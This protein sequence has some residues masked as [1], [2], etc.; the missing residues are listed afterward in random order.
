MGALHAGHMELVNAARL[1][2]DRVIVSVFVNPSQFDDP[3]DLLIYPKRADH[4][5]ALLKAAGVDALFSPDVSDI[6]PDGAETVVHPTR[7]ANILI[8]LERPGHFQGVA[9]V[10]TKLFNIVTPDFA[11]FGQK[12][13]QQLQ[14]IK[15]LVR[16]LCFPIEIIDH[17]TVRDATGLALSSRNV[18]LSTD[19][20]TAATVLNKALD[21][22]QAAV[23]AQISA[24]KLYDM[25]RTR[26]S[27]EPRA[28]IRTIDIVSPDDLS[29]VT[30]QVSD[31][32]AILLAVEFGDVLLIDQRVMHPMPTRRD[33]PTGS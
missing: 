18:H 17:P 28:V 1:A 27:A 6:Y 30:G 7:L 24:D 25:I 10:V 31:E 16:D 4:D 5:H 13:Y 21:L 12:D 11:V 23:L 9:T 26:I 20:R 22:A 32:I 15:R 2:A 33:T 14:L 29:P 19:D 3:D 8:G